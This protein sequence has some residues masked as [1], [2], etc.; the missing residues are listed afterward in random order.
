[1]PAIPSPARIG[2]LWIAAGTALAPWLAVAGGALAF[3]L[4]TAGDARAWEQPPRLWWDA[5][6]T[7]NGIETQH[8][9]ALP[10]V[11]SLTTRL[12]FPVFVRCDPAATEI[13]AVVTV[14]ENLLDAVEL[15]TDGDELELVIATPCRSDLP[16]QIVLTL[17]RLRRLR[18][19]GPAPVVVEE[20]AGDH[21]RLDD[22]SAGEV[23]LTGAL[24][25]LEI[26]LYG[27][28]G[29]VAREL[30]ARR[31]VIEV[32][33]AG[34][35]AIAAGDTLEAR[36]YGSGDVVCTGRP[37]QADVQRFGLGRIVYR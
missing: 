2:S 20:L 29:V 21:L 4:A 7:G 28:G 22:Y 24:D 31:I 34:D 37:V 10:A 9:V 11:T 26:A 23:T 8:T 1:V 14:D 13:S 15:R 35:V 33:G 30:A 17:P 27:R 18:A 19:Y 16:A 32:A 36:L 6:A 12:P 5:V 25:R 3:W